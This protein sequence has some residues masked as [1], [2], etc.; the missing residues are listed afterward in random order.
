MI[1]IEKINGKMYNLSKPKFICT[2]VILSFIISVIFIPITI[3]YEK[4]MG[5]M[6]GPGTKNLTTLF[7]SIAIIA[8]L[9]ETL[10]FQMGII[11]LFSLN[12]KF[13]SNK[14]LL[15]FI[16]AIFFGGDHFYSILYIFYG[17]TMG[18]LLAYSFIVYEDKQNSG[19]WITAII[20]SLIRV[21]LKT[22]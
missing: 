17:F 11:K 5:A 21:C 3:I 1:S 2:I 15:M 8:P 18:L 7:I 22:N 12:K 14:L 16:S 19:Y 13:K 9:W 4:Y 20:H 6:G 10:I